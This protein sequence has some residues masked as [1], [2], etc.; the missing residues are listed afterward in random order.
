MNS[1]VHSVHLQVLVLIISVS[2]TLA[3]GSVHTY[4][5]RAIHSYLETT[6]YIQLTTR[7]LLGVGGTAVDWFAQQT[8]NSKAPWNKIDPIPF[9]KENGFDWLRVGV[10]TLSFPELENATVSSHPPWQDGFWSSREYALNVMKAGAKVGMHLDLFFFLSDH[11]TMAGQQKAAAGWG[12]YSLE[13]TAAALRQHTYDTTAY[14]RKKG[15]KIELYEVGNEIDLG[16]SGYSFDTK[17][18]APR[19]DVSKDFPWVRSNIWTKEAVLLRAAIEGITTADPAAKIVLHLALIEHPAFV[20]AFFQTMKD[21]EVPYDYGALSY[22]PWLHYNPNRS[23]DYF[24]QSVSAIVASRKQVIIAEFDFPSSEP[25]SNLPVDEVLGYSFTAE[26]QSTW[27]RDFLILANNDSIAYAFYFYP[28]NFLDRQVG[29]ASLFAN[30]QQPKPA[31]AEFKSF[32]SVNL[33][34]ATVTSTVISATTLSQSIITLT[35]TSNAVALLDYVFYGLIGVLAVAVAS[36]VHKFRKV[37]VKENAR[38]RKQ[39]QGIQL[40]K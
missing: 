30:D 9:L 13:Q 29:E 10:T 16:V 32:H 14:Y 34:S 39:N 1:H 25:T 22:Y 23:P 38:Q 27:V 12:N 17:L 3:V 35:Q 15:L 4:S 21:F 37:R 11:A 8:W 31:L 6:P 40:D 24:N 33:P 5:A 18:Y 7:T 19:V 2:L 26:G 36:T 20:Q 28:D